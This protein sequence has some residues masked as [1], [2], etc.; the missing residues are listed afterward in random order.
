MPSQSRLVCPVPARPCSGSR[1]SRAWV[2]GLVLALLWAQ[3]LG[4]V[5]SV[6]H[7]HGPAH[8]P[9]HGHA[10]SATHPSHAHRAVGGQD[11]AALAHVS[12]GVLGHLQ[13]PTEDVNDCRLYDQLG[14]AGPVSVPFG[15]RVHALPLVPAWVVLQSLQPRACVPFEARA[16]PV[17]R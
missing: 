10:A 6:R 15:L 9:G 12:T 13:V 2:W 3:M 16:P 4:L 14:H 5:H 17:S 1:R 11:L 8:V 7:V